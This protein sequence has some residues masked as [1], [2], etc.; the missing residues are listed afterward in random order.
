L[1]HRGGAPFIATEDGWQWRRELRPGAV[2]ALNLW[3][4][5]N[6]GGSGPKVVN[7]GGHRCSDRAADNRGPRSFVFSPNYP[8]RFKVEN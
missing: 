8:N 1:L 2:V 7:V 3:A 4:P 5:Q 6:G